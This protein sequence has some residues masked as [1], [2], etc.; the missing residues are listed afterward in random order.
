MTA[1]I[2]S[3]TPQARYQRAAELI[4]PRVDWT[5]KVT[6]NTTVYPYWIDGSDC[7]WYERESEQGIEYRLVDAEQGHN[8]AAFDQQALATALAEQSG[9]TVDAHNLPLQKLRVLALVEGKVAE[10]HFEALG[11]GWEFRTADNSLQPRKCHPGD[12]AISPDGQWAAYTRDHNIYLRNLSTQQE[13]P[14]TQDGQACYEYAGVPSVYGR[15]EHPSLQLL[16]S[17]DSSRIFT[18]LTDTRDVQ[19][20][21]PLVQYVPPGDQIKPLVIDAD[22][23]AGLSGDEAI[24]TYTF[25]AIDVASGQIQSADYRPCPTFYPPYIGFF[26]SQRGWWSKDS[27]H[28]YFVDLARGGQQG[29]LVA[30]DTHSGDCQVLI[31]ERD[32]VHVTLI[33]PSHT[34]TLIHYLPASDELIWY[35]ERSG[36]GHLY[37]Y[38]LRTGRLKNPITQGEWL[39]SAV[40]HVDTERRE[41][42][43]KT[44]GRVAGRNPYY[45]DICRVSLDSGEL[46]PVLST[47]HE[48][49]VRDERA[50]TGKAAIT[51]GLDSGNGRGVSAS[52]RFVVST[53]S[54]PDQMP[55][56]LLLDRQGR[57]LQTLETGHVTHLPDNWQWPEPVMLTAADG[58]TDIYAV[59]FRPSDFSA[60]QSY[61]VLDCSCG[62]NLPVGSFTNGGAMGT[63]YAAGAAYAELGFIV[64]MVASRGTGLRSKAFRADKLS[65]ACD[66]PNIPDHIAAIEQLARRYPYMDLSRVGAVTQTSSALPVYALLQYPDFYRVGIAVNACLDWRLSGAFV[67]EYYNAGL[68]PEQKNNAELYELADKLKGKLLIVH[69]MLDNVVPVA[70]AFRLIE[71]LQLANKNVD[72]V[73][74][75]NLG[76]G[77]SKYVQRCAWDYVL[78]HLRGEEPPEAFVL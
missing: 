30:F 71:A 57:A 73:L 38:D 74:L 5:A 14:L 46:S 55:E 51:T 52:G 54:R 67:E 41:L 7:F 40:L 9:T 18:L 45:N 22:L 47:D 44:A 53:R 8:Q 63:F 42:W 27:R 70:A 32:P 72:M 15:R 20:R 64:V 31:E 25:L 11:Q 76:H 29:R 13:R 10:L 3:S 28:A 65:S 77:P 17:P 48:Y 2:D 23:R 39:V 58:H 24:E 49:T 35:S 60:E 69:G 33:P 56:T 78:R 26:S 21:A 12:W 59:V 43:I 4:K 37:L 68:P 75:P 19:T 16:W 34:H 66:G 62:D 1:S 50:K 6:Y 61:P 36:W